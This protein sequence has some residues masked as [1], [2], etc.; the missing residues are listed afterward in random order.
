MT[1]RTN[2]LQKVTIRGRG[3][4]AHRGF[5]RSTGHLVCACSCPGSMN[6]TLVKKCIV[7]AEGWERANCGH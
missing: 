7:I 3:G 6:G 4:K 2:E 1:D 5:R